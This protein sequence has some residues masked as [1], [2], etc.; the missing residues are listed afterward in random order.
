[1]IDREDANVVLDENPDRW[2]MFPIVHADLWLKYKQHIASFWTTEEIDLADDLIQWDNSLTPAERYF[3]THILA[4]FAAS[5]GLV[6]ENLA[7]RFYSEV[8]LPEAR[9]FYSFQ[10]A[11][12]A[13]HGETYALLIQTY[14]KD[15]QERLRLF[16]AI[17][18]F[19]AIRAKALWAE[20]WMK[21]DRSFA[22]RLIAFAAVEGVLFSGSFCAIFWL[23]KRGLLKGLAFAND[24]IS[25]DEGLHTDFACNLYEKLPSRDKLSQH[26]V[27]EIIRGAVE[28]EEA[29]ICE[30]L[31]C[32]LVGM[33]GNKM[34]Q[35]ICFVAD[36]LLTEL[37]YEKIFKVQ[38]PFDW[39]EM[40]SMQGKTN[41]FEARVSS[42]QKAM[43]MSTRQRDGR[44]AGA[45]FST[46]EDF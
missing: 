25:R 36:R 42:Y 23:R 2:V 40:I 12:E 14:V 11:M 17:R 13:I 31:P 4:F 9:A 19:P 20:Q 16:A 33:S 6:T 29:F 8:Q 15:E 26:R 24:L 38:N 7:A 37:G 1:M 35:Y 22:E 21:S 44:M 32:D 45:V 46:T 27:A 10:I 39:M 5:D 34:K 3:I 43:V 41:F 18:T 30:S 28:V